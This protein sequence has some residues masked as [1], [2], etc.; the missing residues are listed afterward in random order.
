[1]VQLFKDYV[2]KN[3][4]FSFTDKVL[5]AVSGGIDSVCMAHLFKECGVDAAIA[6]CN[7]KL[8]GDESDADEAFVK[9]LAND[10]DFPFF[11]MHFD[12]TEYAQLQKVSIQMAARTLRYNWFEN[13]RR[14]NNYKCIAIAHNAD[15]AIETFFINLIRGTGIQGLTG[16]KVKMNKVVRPLL[17]AYRSDIDKY[18]TD[19]N[20][21]FRTDSSNLTDKYLRNKI[22][23]SLIPCIESISADFKNTM[24]ENLAKLTD[25]ENVYSTAVQDNIDHIVDYKDDGTVVV[26]ILQILNSAAPQTIAFEV[27][28]KFGFSSKFALEIFAN[29]HGISGQVY[30]S[31]TKRLVKDRDYLIIS[32]IDSK[33]DNRFYVEEGISEIN[34]PVKLRFSIRSAD[35]F[36]IPKN[37]SVAA[38]D[39]DKVSFPVLFRKWQMGDYFQPIGMKGMKKVSDFFI[40]QKLSLPAKENTWLMTNAG[41]IVWI[42]GLRPDDRYKITEE[43]KRV[44]LIEYIE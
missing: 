8:R 5:I 12:T 30:Y 34:E 3:N 25:A 42:V 36:E 14:I 31:E 38:L 20:K 32:D 39:A 17:F 19:G 7:F 23:H 4:L 26:S 6:H 21:L 10:L 44:L 41:D 16:I 9:Q 29:L 13:L 22:R 43:T 11:V 33:T 40:D 24:T 18:M 2:V 27:L 28:K 1:M 37:K 15:D 35:N